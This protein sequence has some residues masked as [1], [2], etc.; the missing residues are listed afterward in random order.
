MGDGLGCFAWAMW[1]IPRQHAGGVHANRC[2]CCGAHAPLWTCS[3]A[4]LCYLSLSQLSAPDDMAVG[5]HPSACM[6]TL[7]THARECTVV[8]AP[9]Q[10]TLVIWLS[11]LIIRLPEGAQTLGH[12]ARHALRP[13][14]CHA[15]LGLTF[16]GCWQCGV[17]A[18]PADLLET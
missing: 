15:F 6:Q 3:T 8:C 7:T 9:V 5:L 17:A 11:A 1:A 18:C 4:A 10:Y 16:V 2:S 13:C 12:L 14:L